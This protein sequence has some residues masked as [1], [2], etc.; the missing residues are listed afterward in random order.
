VP[1]G[2]HPQ[3][4]RPHVTIVGAAAPTEDARAEVFVDAPYL[5][6]E[7]F[8]VVAFGVV[9]PDQLFKDQGRR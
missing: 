2:R 6:G 8:W 7:A 9:E 4:E 5:V 1:G 3:G